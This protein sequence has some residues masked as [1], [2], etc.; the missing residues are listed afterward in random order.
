MARILDLYRKHAAEPARAHDDVEPVVLRA[1]PKIEPADDENSD[2]PFIEIGSPAGR[3]MSKGLQ[4]LAPAPTIIPMPRPAAKTETV[5]APAVTAASP[6]AY[7]HI[8]FQALPLSQ[9]PLGPLDRRLAQE[10]VAY[11]APDHP[12]AE[13]Y[14]S[15][16]REFESQLRLETGKVLLFSSAQPGA[17][18]TS[19]VLNLGLT[20]ARQGT[21]VLVV[22][23]NLRRPAIAERLGIGAGPGLRDV[24]TRTVP[25]PWAIQNSGLENLTVLAH[26]NAGVEPP[27][28]AW[29]MLLDQLRGRTDFTLIDAADWSQAESTRLGALCTAIFLVLRPTDLTAESVSRLADEIPKQGGRL[30]GYVLV[31][32]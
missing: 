27:A 26:G 29:T 6:L 17:G 14:R 3:V 25:L 22:D 11:H 5:L 10:L 18:K 21:R 1:D 15:L 16:A 8:A 28:D 19:V 2:V 31:Q 32:R 9:G 23:A 7:Y 24:L 4:N 20:M 30:R 13:Q 12:V